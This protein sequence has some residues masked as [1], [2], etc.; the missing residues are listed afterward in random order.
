MDVVPLDAFDRLNQRWS[1][2]LVELADERQQREQAEKERDQ[3]ALQVK[4]LSS[5]VN[6]AAGEE[7][8]E[9]TSEL[10]QDARARHE[11]SS[12]AVR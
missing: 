6:E 10:P 12:G 5:Y 7:S 4:N 8:K 2:A 3:L 11:R 1:D 9:G